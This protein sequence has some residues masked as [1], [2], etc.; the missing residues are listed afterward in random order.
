[1]VYIRGEYAGDICVYHICRR[2]VCKFAVLHAY[3]FTYLVS[4]EMA[5]P[6]TRHEEVEALLESFEHVIRTL[7]RAEAPIVDVHRRA[8][9][10]WQDWVN[11]VSTHRDQLCQ[12]PGENG[13]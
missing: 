10:K 4:L 2:K 3:V 6:Y 9:V 5:Y 8:N 13:L 1:M 11:S 7:S 12:V